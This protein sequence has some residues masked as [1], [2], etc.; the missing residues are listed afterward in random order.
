MATVEACHPWCGFEGTAKG[1][2]GILTSALG[3]SLPFDICDSAILASAALTVTVELD[4]D[5]STAVSALSFLGVSRCFEERD[6]EAACA[7]T[8]KFIISLSILI[9]FRFF[10]AIWHKLF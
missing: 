3:A 9:L 2:D 8:V 4:S 7:G 5:V 1:A 6:T 10:G